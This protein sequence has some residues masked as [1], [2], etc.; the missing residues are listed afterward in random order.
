MCF[1]L[2]SVAGSVV[3]ILMCGLQRLFA[4]DEYI[5]LKHG[6]WQGVVLIYLILLFGG[7]LINLWLLASPGQY[8]WGAVSLPVR[9][10]LKTISIIWLIGAII[11]L[12][13]YTVFRV[14]H[15]RI[16]KS[17]TEC[18]DRINIILDEVKKAL[19]LSQEVRA[20]QGYGLTAPELIGF[21]RPIIYLPGDTSYT[22]E[23][24]KAIVAHELYHYK[25]RDKWFRELA[26]IVQ[27]FNW[28]NP[29]IPKINKQLEFWDEIC[30]DFE[31]INLGIATNERYGQT[32]FEMACKMVK[33]EQEDS[34]ILAISMCKK[35]TFIKERIVKIMGYKGD[36][37]QKM[38]L[39]GICLIGMMLLGSTTAL[40]AGHGAA[41]VLDKA[42]DMTIIEYEEKEEVLLELTEYMRN[43][44]DDMEGLQMTNQINPLAASEGSFQTNLVDSEW[45]SGYFYARAGQAIDVYVKATPDNV[46][47]EVGIYDPSGILRYVLSSGNITHTFQV[48]TT[49]AYYVYILNES[50]TVVSVRGNY[51]TWDL[52]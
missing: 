39:F 51:H 48:N 9:S 3:Y 16:L 2:A 44:E 8:L 37:N 22:D 14:R 15:N 28:F 13:Y 23:Q 19:D 24:I 18:E 31:V 35:N 43:V 29:V 32:L 12:T 40:A 42:N 36:V 4:G 38:R 7:W 6:L 27:C 25:H 52:E 20:I 21:I 5:K 26:I 10:I 49:G 17:A 50:N 46:D 1:L 41:E 33:W 47:I 30:C 45:R 11:Q 34:S